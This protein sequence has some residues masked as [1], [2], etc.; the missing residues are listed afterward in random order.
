MAPPTYFFPRVPHSRLADHDKLSQ[1]FLAE[2]GLARTFDDVTSI[3]RDC[4]CVD[5]TGIGPGG[6]SGCLLTVM[7][8]SGKA[9]I[10]VGFFPEFQTWK[11]VLG[12]RVWVGVDREYPP[13]PEDLIRKRTREG[14]V[15]E[16]NDQQWK[17]PVIN[18]PGGLTQLECEWTWDEQGVVQE[19]VA[20][21]YRDMWESFASVKNMLF[22]R[23]A[24]DFSMNRQEGG[25]RCIDAL[26]INYRFGPVEQNILKLISND[27]W[28]TI[29]MAAVD[30]PTF[31]AA[32][33]FEEGEQKKTSP[34][35]QADSQSTSPGS[36]DS[37]PTIDPVEAS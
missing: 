18:G 28:I 8:T 5:L 3:Q 20:E 31:R 11:A 19:A 32:V 24:V 6:A 25:D 16:L 10:R 9:P 13:T 23:D 27:T 35:D 29:L 33:E 15:I 34:E 21:T 17:I 30:Y 4:S 26:T 36:G 14:Y 37:C 12:D 7:P 22:D 2:V 1:S